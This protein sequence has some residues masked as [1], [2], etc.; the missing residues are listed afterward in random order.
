MKVGGAPEH[1]SF[2]QFAGT[3]ALEQGLQQILQEHEKALRQLMSEVWWK[4][5]EDSRPSRENS[6]LQ[7]VH[8]ASQLCKPPLPSLQV[9]CPNVEDWDLQENP[10]ETMVVCNKGVLMHDSGVQVERVMHDSEVQVDLVTGVRSQ[11]FSQKL[12]IQGSKAEDVENQ[13]FAYIRRHERSSMMNWILHRLGLDNILDRTSLREPRRVGKLAEFV[14]SH[15]FQAIVVAVVIFNC[16]YTILDTNWEMRHLGQPKFVSTH[17][18]EIS[19]AC[20]Y[21][22]EVM[23]RLI[24]HRCYFFYN[25][26]MSWNILDLALVVINSAE[27]ILQGTGLKGTNL[28][29]A[30]TMRIFRVAKVLR[31]IRLMYFLTELKLMVTCLLNSGWNLLWAFVVLGIVKLLYAV[32]LVQHIA[33]FLAKNKGLIPNNEKNDL[34]AAFGSVEQGVLTLFQ[35]ISGGQDWGGSYKIISPVGTMAKFLYISYIIIMWLSVTNII[36]SMFIEKALKIARPDMEEKM[37]DAAEDDLEA[38]KELKGIFHMMD[39]DK[40]G[41]LSLSEFQISL[42]DVRIQSYFETREIS[43]SQAIMLFEMLSTPATNDE[44]DVDT[45]VTGCLRMRGY[46]TNVD[47]IALSHQVQLLSNTLSMHNEEHL[48]G[49]RELYANICQAL[50]NYSRV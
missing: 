50:G 5:L 35:D 12:D 48:K 45:F 9:A 27:L 22:V 33:G 46:A 15:T 49:M 38:I 36:S 39:L 1:T 7:E 41:K 6:V 17:I 29:V 44:I 37:L 26:D 11:V 10:V 3:A 40:S 30:R 28:I 18:L 13:K 4:Y 25:G 20:F 42:K 21:L 23:L 32:L 14:Q 43:I 24:V 19:L 2:A 47:M 8:R 31:V 16:I 34:V